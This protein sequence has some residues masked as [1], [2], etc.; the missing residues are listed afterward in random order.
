FGPDAAQTAEDLAPL[1]GS[2]GELR[3]PVRL[4]LR[5]RFE[6]EAGAEEA[7][8]VAREAAG[9]LAA[10][11]CWDQALSILARYGPRSTFVATLREAIRDVPPPERASSCI[12][13]MTD[14]DAS[15]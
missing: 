12:E 9:R 1:Q 6:V 5:R 7:P 4:A 13:H 15:E 8:A 10:A 11:S 3:P 14:E 2:S